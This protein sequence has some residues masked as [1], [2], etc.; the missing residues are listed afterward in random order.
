[1]QWYKED[2]IVAI[3]DGVNC[4]KDRREYIKKTA[5][6]QKPELSIRTIFIEIIVNDPEGKIIEFLMF[7]N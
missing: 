1:M 6:S 5:K 7:I 4:S 3:L 2:G